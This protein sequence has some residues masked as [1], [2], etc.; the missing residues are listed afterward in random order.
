MQQEQKRSE[1]LGAPVLLAGSFEEKV[2]VKWPTYSCD[3]PNI[4]IHGDVLENHESASPVEIR[5]SV[6]CSI[7]VYTVFF[8]LI[9]IAAEVYLILGHQHDPLRLPVLRYV[10][11]PFGIWLLISLSSIIFRWQSR[12]LM[13]TGYLEFYRNSS[14]VW[15]ISY[16]ICSS[17]F[18]FGTTFFIIAQ[19]SMSPHILILEDV[20][21]VMQSM[22]IFWSFILLCLLW[23]YTYLLVDYIRH[24]QKQMLPDGVNASDYQVLPEVES[25]NGRKSS[26]ANLDNRRKK[27]SLS[28]GLHATLQRQAVTIRFLEKQL[29]VFADRIQAQENSLPIAKSMDDRIMNIPSNCS[30]QEYQQICH[31]KQ[32]LERRVNLLESNMQSQQQDIAMLQQQLNSV[33]GIR[34]RQDKE[35]KKVS[36]ALTAKQLKLNNMHLLLAVE[37][38][39]ADKARVLIEELSSRCSH[40]K[41]RR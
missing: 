8:V 24:N 13:M 23:L 31:E 27:S 35:L 40:C 36:E 14:R 30:L 26:T 2:D 15:K 5:H 7:I 20:S 19:Q 18:A 33:Q 41:M 39:A 38:E 34:Q 32:L 21:V 11:I 22:F 25:S 37:R 12:I 6:H 3:G 10:L 28:R 16:A 1:S 17:G 29:K 9:L 4:L